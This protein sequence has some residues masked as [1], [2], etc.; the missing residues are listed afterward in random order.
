MCLNGTYFYVSFSICA[1]AGACAAT[2]STGAT[3]DDGSFTAA[4]GCDCCLIA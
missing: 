3:A 1:A 4:T 2:G